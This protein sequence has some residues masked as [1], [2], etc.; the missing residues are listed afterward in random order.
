[1]ASK[2][3]VMLNRFSLAAAL[4]CC[5][6]QGQDAGAEFEVA[7][8]K[9]AAPNQPG[10]NIEP[11]AKVLTMRNVTLRQAIQF[12]WH[13]HEYQMSGGPK[14]VDSDGFDIVGK[15]AESLVS[16]SFNDRT[17]RLRVM[18]RTLLAERFQ[19]SMR[20]ET[21][22]VPA[23]ALS[24]AKNGLQLKRI[25]PG[26]PQQIFGTPDRLVAKGSSIA[27]FAALLAAKFQHPVV[28]RT[29]IEGLYNFQVLFA[30]DTVPD[31]PYPAIFT[32]LQEQ[33][34]LRLDRATA[35]AEVFV[36]ERAERP[37]EN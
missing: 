2:Q 16:L 32:A 17:D 21:K 20:R 9:P 13:L 3:L 25:E 26:G 28:D 4:I 19:L 36:I 27:E 7:T 34:G 12:A 37:S 14:W 23:Y 10:F 6:A 24:V 15:S 35:P 29:G 18:L 11:S 5:A 30:P 22:E 1:M 8:V 33:C 31:S